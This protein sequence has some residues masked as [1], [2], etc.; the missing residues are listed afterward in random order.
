CDGHSVRAAKQVLRVASRVRRASARGDEDVL[1]VGA[2]EQVAQLLAVAALLLD[3]PRERGRLLPQLLLEVRAHD[4]TSVT[5]SREARLART[6]GTYP[7]A[8]G[9]RHTGN[10]V[11][12]TIAPSTSAASRIHSCRWASRTT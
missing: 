10:P 3:Q 8:R 5:A 4:S 6:A 1:H 11:S 12:T 2:P 7:G 9:G